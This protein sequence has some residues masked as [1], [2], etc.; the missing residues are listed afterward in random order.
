MKNRRLIDKF[1]WETDIIKTKVIK[2]L[3]SFYK[4]QVMKRR[5]TVEVVKERIVPMKDY[6]LFGSSVFGVN[7]L[8]G[9]N[10]QSL[11]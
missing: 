5:V 11:F 2:Y 7:L 9:V 10:R 3:L 6:S 1:K 8:Y 4:P